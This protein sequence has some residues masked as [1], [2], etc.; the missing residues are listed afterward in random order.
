MNINQGENKQ[1][2]QQDFEKKFG[3]KIDVDFGDVKKHAKTG[4]K[5][6]LGLIFIIAAIVIL[7]NCFYVVR[8]DEVATVRELGEIKRIIVD[9]N[10]D[11][12][13]MQ[14][15]MDTRF[16]NVIIDTNKGLKFKIPFIT[17]VEKDTSK[18]LT[19]V[20]NISRKSTPATR[21]S[22]RSA[23]MRNGKSHIPA[24]SELLLAQ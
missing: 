9:A 13:K 1:E 15:D 10:S 7:S 17:T 4:L 8:E 6:I 20:S 5:S 14:N 2:A 18:L 22:M 16:Q 11:Y 23:C 24:C 19:Y 3:K 12:A 21:S